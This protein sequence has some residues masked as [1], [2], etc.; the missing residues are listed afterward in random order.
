M[1]AVLEAIDRMSAREKM[2]TANY[3]WAALS[4]TSD[5]IPSWHA[6]ELSKTAM[7]VSEGQEHPIPWSMAKEL[8]RSV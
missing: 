6:D 1:P 4:R 3:I 8:L 7:R 2:E 5:Q